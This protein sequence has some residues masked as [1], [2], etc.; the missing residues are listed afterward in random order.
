M[1]VLPTILYKWRVQSLEPYYPIMEGY[2]K[3]GGIPP[4][5]NSRRHFGTQPL[6]EDKIPRLTIWHY[7]E[8]GV[9]FVQERIK[10]FRNLGIY[11]TQGNMTF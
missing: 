5:N 11:G 8:Q 9:H 1:V 2:G 3:K 10:E 4:P 7:Y 6:V